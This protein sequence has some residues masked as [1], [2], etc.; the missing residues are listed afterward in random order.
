MRTLGSVLT[1][2]PS[3]LDPE[4]LLSSLLENYGSLTFWIILG[5]IFAECGLLLGF[6]L[7]G[8]SLLFITGLFLAGTA[9]GARIEMNVPVAIVLLIIAAILGNVVG[10]WIGL[11][12]GPALFRRPDSRLFKQVYVE[13]TGMFFER[14]GARAIVLARFVP[15]VR[16]FIT[17]VAGVGRMDARRYFIYSAVGGVLW[18]G[19]VT[20]LGFYLGR[21]PWIAR[22]LEIVLILIVLISVVPMI[23]EW[24]RHRRAARTAS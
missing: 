10:Y 7:P 6:F 4:N 21:I 3:W 12:A 1:L 17:A 8:D 18:A 15:I 24:W 2:G 11:K 13:R 22:N 9:S 5:I 23:I 20:I 16:T 19:G 14:Y